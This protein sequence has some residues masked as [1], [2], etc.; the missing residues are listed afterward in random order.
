LLRDRDG[1]YGLEFSEMAKCMG[2]H[3][4][5]HPGVLGKTPISSD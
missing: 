5:L 2:I 3:E 1:A 4:V